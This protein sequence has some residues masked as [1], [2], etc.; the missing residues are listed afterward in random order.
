MKNNNVSDIKL[1]DDAHYEMDEHDNF[2]EQMRENA[3]RK[4]ILIV[5]GRSNCF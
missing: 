3:I 2:V 4:R 5:E 1:K